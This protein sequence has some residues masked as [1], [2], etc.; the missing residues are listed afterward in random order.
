LVA[1]GDGWAVELGVFDGEQLRLAASH[2]AGE[3]IERV[4]WLQIR[5]RWGVF[6]AVVFGGAAVGDQVDARPVPGAGERGVRP[7]AGELFGATDDDR[8]LDGGALA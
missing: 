2:R 6:P 4:G 8:V 3:C 5:L 7:S 1:T